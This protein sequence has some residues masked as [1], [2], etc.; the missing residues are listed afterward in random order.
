[1]K[2][3]SMC[4][5]ASALLLFFPLCLSGQPD[6]YVSGSANGHDYANLGLPSGTYWAICNVGSESYTDLGYRFAWGE[7]ESKTDFNPDNYQYMLEV[8]QDPDWGMY[9]LCQ[10]LG[11]DIGGTC[12]DM[13]RAS[14][15]GGWRLPTQADLYELYR[16]CW[17]E[18]VCENGVWGTRFH[19]PN[20]NS[21]FF[22][23]NNFDRSASYWSSTEIK[24]SGCH[25]DCNG[26]AVV[27]S[28]RDNAANSN[29]MFKFLGAYVRPII[30]R[31]EVGL[32]QTLSDAVY[33]SCDGSVISL[34]SD[35]LVRSL[36][37]YDLGGH[38][39]Y[40]VSNPSRYIYGVSLSDGVY[41]ARIITEDGR[42][43]TRKLV[44]GE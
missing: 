26:H 44:V 21:I 19:G 9:F 17:D 20:D 34:H 4:I 6:P 43:L 13:A 38:V 37:L 14:W 1:M 35:C 31:T 11:E 30:R 12:Y 25:P 41:V 27:L 22:P 2:K 23:H 40:S 24:P 32:D 15:G 39:L 29:A 3:I 33:V 16:Y 28:A 5:T 10:D 8:L 36:S 18:H 42:S 7:T